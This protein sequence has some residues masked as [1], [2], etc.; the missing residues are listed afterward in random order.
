MNADV[1]NVALRLA[2]DPGLSCRLSW[3]RLAA[4][5]VD[6]GEI[7]EDITTVPVNP[8]LANFTLELPEPPAMK[9][10]GDRELA[11]IE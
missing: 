11:T 9:L 2:V 4:R 10:A 8:L 3:L 7:V 1:V 6:W 5:S